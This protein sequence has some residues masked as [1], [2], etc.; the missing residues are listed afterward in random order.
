MI[1]SDQESQVDSAALGAPF[2]LPGDRIS[3]TYGERKLQDLPR[4]MFC[5]IPLPFWRGLPVARREQDE[6][7]LLRDNGYLHCT[8]RSDSFQEELKQGNAH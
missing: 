3:L 8:R 6:L 5:K 1:L 4:T 2:R 7:I